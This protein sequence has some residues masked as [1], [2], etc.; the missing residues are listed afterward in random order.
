MND[1]AGSPTSLYQA[2]RNGSLVEIK[3]NDNDLRVIDKEGCDS[4]AKKI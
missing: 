4:M 3:Y 2:E 1:P